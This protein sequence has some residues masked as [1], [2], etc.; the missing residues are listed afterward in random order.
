MHHIG[1]VFTAEQCFARD[2]MNET[3]CACASS[4]LLGLTRSVGRVDGIKQHG[5]VT[6]AKTVL[7]F[8]AKAWDQAVPAKEASTDPLSSS[9]E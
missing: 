9:S 4:R 5:I 1:I 7:V 3:T 6:T 2:V 8:D